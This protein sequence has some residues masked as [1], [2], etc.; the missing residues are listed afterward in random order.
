M[1]ILITGASGFVGGVLVR[2]C[3]KRKHQ[4]KCLVR[5]TSNLG[6]LKEYPVELVYGDLLDRDSLSKAVQDVDVIYHLAAQ[7]EKVDKQIYDKINYLGTKNLIEICLSYNKNL[8]KFVY[9]STIAAVGPSKSDIPVKEDSVPHPINDYGKTKL[10]AENFIRGFQGKLPFVIARLP[11]VYGPG[12]TNI[13]KF[14]KLA[15]TGFWPA[16]YGGDKLTS[17][18]Y[19]EDVV[20]G[21]ILLAENPKAVNRIYFLTEEKIYKLSEVGKIIAEALGKKLIIIKIPL[22]L[23]LLFIFFQEILFKLIG[24]KP[25]ILRQQVKR[26]VDQNWICSGQKVKEDLGFV[27]P[28]SLSVGIK[29]II[30]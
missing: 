20:Q 8:K 13:N 29:K 9:V 24:R 4:I 14:I 6:Q 16:F 7:I 21:L 10:A 18:I 5:K 3:L 27:A 12:N 30:K 23:L 25:L 11:M 28:T 26:W 15:K 19:V 22:N 2:E 1:K 17:A